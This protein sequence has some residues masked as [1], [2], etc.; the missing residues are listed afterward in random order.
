MT[1]TLAPAGTRSSWMRER[2]AAGSEAMTLAET[3]SPP[4]NSTLMSFMEWTTWAAVITFP[5]ADMST[6]EP[7]SVK[8]TCPPVVTSLPLAR[9]T[10]T[11]GV[12]FLKTSPGVWAAPATG[13][14]RMVKAARMIA[15]AACMGVPFSMRWFTS[16]AEERSVCKRAS[17]AAI[18]TSVE[19]SGGSLAGGGGGSELTH[20][21]TQTRGVDRLLEQE[22]RMHGGRLGD[23]ISL[24]L[25]NEEHDR[26]RGIEGPE[27]SGQHPCASHDAVGGRQV[28]IDHAHIEASHSHE[29]QRM[30][31]VRRHF[32]QA[33]FRFERSPESL[34]A[35]RIGIDQDGTKP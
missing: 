2:S 11:E 17:S 25:G 7:V 20:D 4:R 6:P 16:L 14:E 26:G 35:P 28:E 13:M 33:P 1:A 21:R 24:D 29:R 34:P 18:V 10:T 8:R 22:C 30:L 9:M 5:S 27:E 19:R 3:V 23:E 31:R 15:R 32:D 12:T